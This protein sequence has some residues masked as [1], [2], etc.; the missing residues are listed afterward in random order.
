M[1][2]LGTSQQERKAVNGQRCRSVIFHLP[3]SM[4]RHCFSLHDLQR[5]E[6]V[7]TCHYPAGDSRESLQESWEAF[8]PEAHAVVTGWDS[9]QITEDMLAIAAQLE[10]VVH[11]AG[12]IRSFI[13][14]NIWDSGIRI[15]TSNDSLGLGVAETTLGLIIAGLKGFFPCSDLTRSGYWQ[16]KIPRRGFGRVRELYDVTVGIIG[17]G[18]TGR[19]LLR[20][21]EPF[22][23]TVLLADP[24]I[25]ASE[26][27]RLGAQLVELDGLMGLSDVVSLHAPA[28]PH[29]RHM[30]GRKEFMA[31]KDDAIFINTARGMLVDETALIAALKTQRIS[32]I[33]D[34]TNPEPPAADSPFRELPNV[35]LLPHISGALSTGAV[36]MGRSTV[37]QLL[38]LA[39]GKPMHGEIS[40]E[41][42]MVMA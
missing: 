18:R 2:V 35:A 21:L 30:I 19:H 11:S 26:A 32:A 25:R 1:T 34:V 24:T 37:D 40:Q 27:A 9:P 41:R 42:F 28:L 7:Y 31:M 4:L 3:E 5:L 36:R 14:P 17:A 6:E 8:A 15:A 22:E 20:L 12:S 16:G 33:L 29:L 39:A 23:V 13:P 10:A 38:E